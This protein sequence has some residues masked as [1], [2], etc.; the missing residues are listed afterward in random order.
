MRCCFPSWISY[1]HF[2][3]FSTEWKKQTNKKPFKDS[4]QVICIHKLPYM[5]KAKFS[6]W[7]LE[8][9]GK[10]MQRPYV[11]RS[12]GT[13]PP[14][15]FLWTSWALPH[16]REGQWYPLVA[17]FCQDAFCCSSCLVNGNNLFFTQLHCSQTGAT[18]PEYGGYF[19]ILPRGD[20]LFFDHYVL[21]CTKPQ[22]W[23]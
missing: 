6:Y 5:L 19:N 4:Y 9:F 13:S 1:I 22:P 17:E 11:L 21:A 3:I 10:Q 7:A 20:S 16:Y 14:G 12:L 15:L 8:F 18:W 23:H 2:Y